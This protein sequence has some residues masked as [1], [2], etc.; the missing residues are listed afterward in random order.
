[1]CMWAMEQGDEFFDQQLNEMRYGGGI[2]N[3]IASVLQVFF[4]GEIQ[5]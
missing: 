2:W 5:C 3:M 1:M 4:D